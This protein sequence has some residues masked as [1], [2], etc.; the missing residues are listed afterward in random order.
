MKRISKLVGAVLALAGCGSMS[1]PPQ[2]WNIGGAPIITNPAPRQAPRPSA[3]LPVTATS[4]VR[5]LIG[6]GFD[7]LLAP[8]QLL[9]TWP[10]NRPLKGWRKVQSRR[11]HREIARRQRRNNSRR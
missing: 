4:Q 11:R 6:G 8:V 1:P 3:P 2:S 10:N 5:G 7:D 9:N